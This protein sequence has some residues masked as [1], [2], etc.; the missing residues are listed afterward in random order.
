MLAVGPVGLE[1][2][3]NYRA[4]NPQK[5]STF[6]DDIS[7]PHGLSLLK[8]WNLIALYRANVAVYL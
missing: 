7:D 8:S 1:L 2:S 4:L 6:N 5:S 3:K